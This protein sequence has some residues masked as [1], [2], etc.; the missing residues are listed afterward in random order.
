VDFLRTGLTD[1]RTAIQAA[2]FDHPQLFTNNGHPFDGQWLSG[3][4]RPAHP[5]QATGQQIEVPA[6]GLTGARRFP[7][8]SKILWEGSNEHPQTFASSTWS[9]PD[10]IGKAEQQ[11]TTAV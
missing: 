7:R 10:L 4:E 5:G 9:T 1:Q 3:P 11:K 2:P 6:T 8:S